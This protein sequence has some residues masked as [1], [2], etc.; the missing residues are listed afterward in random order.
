MTE[1]LS[2]VHDSCCMYFVITYSIFLLGK[3]IIEKKLH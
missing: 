2:T 1:Q 3:K